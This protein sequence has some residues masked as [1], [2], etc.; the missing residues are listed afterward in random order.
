MMYLIFNIEEATIKLNRYDGNW[1]A[2]PTSKIDEDIASVY[3]EA[4]TPGLSLFAITG[5]KKEEVAVVAVTPT[6]T[7]AVPTTTTPATTPS[8]TP[9]PTPV[10]T[11]KVPGFEAIFATSSLLITYMY[12][13]V[14][15]KK[16]KK[17]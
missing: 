7:L 4:A 1:T 9:S 3:F 15:R 14:F 17:R 6:P 13:F 8:P 12:L 2:L 5:E 10:P 16:G 11:S